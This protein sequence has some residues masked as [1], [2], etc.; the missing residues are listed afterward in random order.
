MKSKN[1]NGP[2]FLTP[3]N[4]SSHNLVS[5][6]VE[7]TTSTPGMGDFVQSLS[8]VQYQ[9]LLGMLN[10]HL[11]AAKD[12]AESDAS[13]NQAS[14][15]CLS[16]SLNPLIG[17]SQYWIIDSWATSHVCFNRSYFHEMRPI[18]DIF[19]TLSDQSRLSIP[20]IGTV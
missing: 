14:G 8:S 4:Q 3:T 13:Q 12:R 11:G 16:L 20:Y 9:Q 1:P 7:G 6:V 10:N 2:N 17:Q 15:I 19:V 18:K 5:Q